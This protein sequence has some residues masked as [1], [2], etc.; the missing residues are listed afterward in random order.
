MPW[1]RESYTRH[2]KEKEHGVGARQRLHVPSDPVGQ[3][4]HEE[5]RQAELKGQCHR[6]VH[7]VA[8][9]VHVQPCRGM[10]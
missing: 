9:H 1:M 2:K 10:L 5:N 8:L 7:I 4:E 6:I 3:H